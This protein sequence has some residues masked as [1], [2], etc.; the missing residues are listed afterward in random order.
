[1][2]TQLRVRNPRGH[3]SMSATIKIKEVKMNKNQQR[4]MQKVEYEI[5]SDIQY[6]IFDTL[7]NIEYDDFLADQTHD[8]WTNNV[9]PRVKSTMESKYGTSKYQEY[10]NSL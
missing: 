5:A 1:M 2:R 7:T 10:Q 3:M 8:F 4:K 6:E 9:Y